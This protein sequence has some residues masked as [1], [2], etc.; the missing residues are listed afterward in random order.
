MHIM[1]EA[2]GKS[3][4]SARPILIKERDGT[5]DCAPPN[6]GIYPAEGRKMEKIVFNGVKFPV[7]TLADGRKVVMTSKHGFRFSDKSE[8]SGIEEGF[9]LDF[10]DTLKVQREFS[11]VEAA[12]PN[13]ATASTQKLSEQTLA[14]L[15]GL[16]ENTEISVILVPFM[17]ISAMKE[18]GIR[19]AM[20]KVLAYNATPETARVGNPSEKVVDVN[21]WAW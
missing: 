11:E 8:F 12:L 3:R 19:D 15:Q 2:L 5:A 9:P 13:K 10:L 6:A 4:G 16:S 14:T 21:N 20:P 18:M 7:H 1:E 17:V